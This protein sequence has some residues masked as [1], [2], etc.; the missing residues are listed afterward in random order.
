[1]RLWSQNVKHVEHT[2]V[3]A[4]T[5]QPADP[6]PKFGFGSEGIPMHA[7]TEMGDNLGN[8]AE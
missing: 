2:V 3:Q 7:S 4:L 8:K 1:M 5:R 6:L